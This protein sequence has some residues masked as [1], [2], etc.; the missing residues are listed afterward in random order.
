MS[1]VVSNGSGYTDLIPARML[2]EFVYCPRLFY[3]EYVQGEFAHSA[4][5]V[6]GKAVH[7]RVDSESGAMPPADELGEEDPIHARSVML[8][9]EKYGLIA[10]MDLVEGEGRL[11]S[12]VD[13]K[14]GMKPDISEN[15]WPADRA[16][17][18][19]QALILRENGYEC[20]EGI[21]YYSGSKER[22]SIPISDDLVTWTL[23]RLEECRLTSV[24]G[25]CPPPLADSPKC[26][27][28]SLVGICLP[29]EINSLIEAET[30]GEAE[31]EIRRLYPSRDDAVPVYIRDYKA[32]LGKHSDE[33]E[34]K[35]G[36]K[37]IDRVRLMEMSQLSIFTTAQVTTPLLRELCGRNIP[38]CYFSAG[39]WFYGITQ[40]M[41]HK[42]VVLRRKQFAAAEDPEKTVNLARRL[43]E[44]KIKNCRTMLRRNC[45]IAPEKALD[46]L[47]KFAGI[48]SRT[49]ST[50]ALLGVEGSASRIYFMH[51]QDMLKQQDRE[52]VF[53]FESR[54]RR[55]P[56]DPVNAMLSY[57]YALL[58]K[59]ATVA[60]L[61][62]GFDPYMG[63]YHK[64]RYGRPSLALDLME[65]FR[66]LIA[67]SV[68]IGMINN[69]E[70]SADDFIKRGNAVTF[71]GDAKKTVIKAYER[72]MDSQITHP[73]F[74][75]TVSYRRVLEVQ[76]RLISRYI[77]GEIDEYPTFCTR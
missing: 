42:N 48:A 66:P 46:E 62:V 9:S 52:S 27:G 37:V 47:K 60:L 73:V 8:S 14:K 2:N 59:D 70:I 69:K 54:N 44:G 68:V 6:D 58:A 57:T 50:G 3:I 26:P 45:E 72:R 15:A 33:I 29:D 10:R 40:G 63:F 71:K 19:A 16:Q 21:I 23:E 51:F 22:V 53:D 32:V 74:G 20:P 28:C 34:I 1:I 39:G 77:S 12:P 64:P 38:V 36:G 30:A 4:D 75:Y 7:R 31:S 5:T 49:T 11:V 76:A 18:C 13:Y 61:S 67:D 56:K 65:E 24:S 43:I 17:L 35:S 55:P 25:D 41:S